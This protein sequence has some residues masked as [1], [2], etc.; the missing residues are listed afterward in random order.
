MW[1]RGVHVA[2]RK[3]LLEKEIKVKAV[4]CLFDWLV[5]RFID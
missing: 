3:D 4:V 2:D 5:E 1:K